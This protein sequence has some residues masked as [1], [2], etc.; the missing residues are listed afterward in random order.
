M[1]GRG[2]LAVRREHLRVDGAVLRTIV[3]LSGTG[4]VQVFIATSSWLGLIRIVSSFGSVAV[5]GYGIAIRVVLF[6][7]LPSWGMANAAATLMG[8]NLGASRPERAEQ[9]VWRA[10]LYNL[11]F[12]GVAGLLFVLFAEPIVHAFSSDPAVAAYGVNALRIVSAGFLFYA[13]GMVVTQAFNG[14]GDTWTPTLINL[15]CYWLLEIPLA[16]V[17]AKPLALG[18]NGV[19]IA[20]LVAFSTMAVV[21]VVV[22]RRGRWR[23]VTV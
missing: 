20:I 1:A 23:R 5:A 12:L 22:F 11:V 17:L 19:F 14:A 9:A 15:C 8:Q 2:H 6:A 16:W 10:S 3:R 13:Y 4:I 7:L 18:P 21:S